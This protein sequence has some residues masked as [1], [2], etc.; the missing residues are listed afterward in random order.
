[1]S[2]MEVYVVKPDGDVVFHSG[3]KNAFL[4]AFFIWQKL[5]DRYGFYQ[6][7]PIDWRDGITGFHAGR[8]ILDEFRKLFRHMPEMSSTDFLIMESTC[9][10]AI[11]PRD[12]MPRLAEALREFAG[13]YSGGNQ[14]LLADLIDVLYTEDIRGMA[15]CQTSVAQ[16]SWAL[17]ID[18]SDEGSGERSLN[19]DRDKLT[20]TGQK[21]W[22]I[23]ELK[24]EG[25]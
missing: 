15:F 8:A 14:L 4:G 19:I 7:D 18:P 24:E 17:S 23:E 22:F 5:C 1:M 11:V 25:V 2:Q 21:H 10:G 6:A 20:S 3:I 9:D 16:C 12:L 13:V